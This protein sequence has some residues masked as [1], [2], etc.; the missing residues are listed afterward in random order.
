MTAA[1]YDHIALVLRY[2][3]GKIVLLESLRE[4]GVTTCEWDR[5]I[6]LKWYEKYHSV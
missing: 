3:N 2:S 5:F 4:T 6:R 1:D